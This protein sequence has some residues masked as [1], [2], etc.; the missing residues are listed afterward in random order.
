MALVFP[1][2][3]AGIINVAAMARNGPA[4]V[5]SPNDRYIDLFQ[6]V[7]KKL[8]VDIVAMNHMQMDQVR[9]IGCNL[10]DQAPGGQG[11]GKRVAVGHKGKGDMKQEIEIAGKLV[12]ILAI[13][14][15]ASGI[16]NQTFMAL[17]LEQVMNITGNPA[18]TADATQGIDLQDSHCYS[19]V[20]FIS[21][22]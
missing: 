16:G 4:I 3:T 10:A 5:L 8:D 11:G 1:P 21:C 22:R 18:S 2:V 7:E 15:G 19:C 20:F 6:I 17:R 13:F 12:A 9:L 14:R